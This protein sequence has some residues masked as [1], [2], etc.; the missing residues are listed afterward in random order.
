MVEPQ[1]LRMEV[2]V[3]RFILRYGVIAGLIIGVELFVLTAGFR[4]ADEDSTLS[5][6]L[7]YLTMLIALSAIFIGVKRYRDVDRGGVVGFWPALG[8]GIGISVV[9]GIL[10][11][12]SWEATV[13]ITHLDFANGY[14]N[15][16][17]AHEKAKGVTGK[18][19]A[20]V[21]AQMD[22]FKAQYANP[23]YRWPMTF[24]EIFP[25]GVVVSLISAAL[26]CNR[27]FLPMRRIA[28]RP[29]PAAEA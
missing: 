4:G 10:Y 29:G 15:A 28:E 17:I 12:A 21:I 20:D 16:T 8:M 6:F 14:A 11:V 13:A 5:L 23:L 1:P 22:Q 9:A 7:G 19:L 3:I 27:R 24:I 26:L 25:V 2:S 18:A